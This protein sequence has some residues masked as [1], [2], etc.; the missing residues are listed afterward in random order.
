M[1]NQYWKR[2]D[3]SLPTAAGLGFEIKS[4]CSCPIMIKP[5]ILITK[6]LGE[7]LKPSVLLLLTYTNT[8][9]SQ[10][11]QSPN[12]YI[13]VTWGNVRHCH[14]LCSLRRTWLYKSN[15]ICLLESI[16]WKKWNNTPGEESIT[17]IN[18]NSPLNDTL[19]DKHGRLMH[20]LD[21]YRVGQK[22]VYT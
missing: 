20:P 22:K 16:K 7:D 13:T 21:L 14:V 11:E 3:G 6:S 5:L 8:D 15:V 17:N 18:S 12:V 10:V 2:C 1:S 9:I 19:N 4:T